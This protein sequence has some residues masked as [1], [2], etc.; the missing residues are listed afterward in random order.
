MADKKEAPFNSAF[1]SLAA[2][3]QNMQQK[4][5]QK[6]QVAPAVKKPPLPPPGVKKS[7]LPKPVTAAA[8]AKEAA[9]TDADLALFHRAMNDARKVAS[10]ERVEVPRN[11]KVRSAT[12]ESLALADFA[13]SVDFSGQFSAMEISGTT[14]HHVPGLNK[15][16]LETLL[17]TESRPES[18]V[19][20]HGL[21]AHIAEQR[22]LNAVRDA[23]R[24]GHRR[25]LIVTG[26]GE[27]GLGVLREL[28]PEW[29]QGS[30]L[31]RHVL[32]FCLA[33]RAFG[34]DGALCVLLR[35]AR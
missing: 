20:L 17:F 13:S 12:E 15:R 21:R 31:S 23:R 27:D 10:N 5:Q 16:V 1:A 6:S 28:V 9:G 22:V 3:K 8:S 7:S 4:E 34:G 2:L 19:D 25:M 18:E 35:R 33:P 14:V 26:K 24:E 30:Q 32:A 11:S 29:L